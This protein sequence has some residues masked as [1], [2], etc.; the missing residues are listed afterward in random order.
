MARNPRRRRVSPAIWI[1]LLTL[2]L[3]A[4]VEAQLFP[5]LPIKRKKQD[6]ANEPPYYGQVRHD[7]FGYY[8]TCWRKFPEG[9]ACPC[10]NP[11]APNVAAEFQKLK[12]DDK[13][14]VPPTDE[15]GM[16]PAPGDNA[17]GPGAGDPVVPPPNRPGPGARPN[18][19]PGANDPGLPALPPA[20]QRSPFELDPAKPAAP[21]NPPG[22][23]KPRDPFEPPPRTSSRLGAPA[24]RRASSP[25]NAPQTPAASLPELPDLAGTITPASGDPG[26]GPELSVPG[27]LLT[28]SSNGRSI[29]LGAPMSSLPP[30]ATTVDAASEVGNNA[31]SQA[32]KRQGIISGLFN[33]RRR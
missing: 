6:C 33:R 25:G 20:D 21:A 27:G 11:E 4:A 9:W 22:G 30:N 31:P 8:P 1:T 7:Y 2:G 5:N 28:D 14:T 32:P 18:P 19:A 16:G 23:A 26:A 29:T 24:T 15:E 12:R 17:A 10:P 3:P 13:P